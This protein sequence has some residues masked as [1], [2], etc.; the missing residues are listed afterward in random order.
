MPHFH[1]DKKYLFYQSEIDAWM[2]EAFRVNGNV[3]P[4]KKVAGGIR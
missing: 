1:F 2:A 4:M 3:M